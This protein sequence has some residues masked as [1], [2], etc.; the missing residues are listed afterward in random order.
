MNQLGLFHRRALY[1]VI[2]I[3]LATGVIW[4]VVHYW[5]AQLGIDEHAAL[6]LNATLMKVHG[7]GAMVF[8]VL[9]GSLV[10]GHVPAGLRSQLNRTSGIAMMAALVLLAATG[11]LLYY[12]GSDTLREAASVVHLVAGLVLP[13]LV[14][15][16]VARVVQSRSWRTARQGAE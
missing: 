8:L 16:H 11:Y 2:G 9:A 5:P 14:G 3:L 10:P 7:A 13:L 1:G 12:A 15:V 6:A 4:A